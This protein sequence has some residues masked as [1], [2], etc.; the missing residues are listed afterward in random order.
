MRLLEAA[1]LQIAVDEIIVE[2]RWRDGGAKFEDMEG[3]SFGL[4][5]WR[6]R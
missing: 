6:F 4:C 3:D 2:L 5:V 1:E